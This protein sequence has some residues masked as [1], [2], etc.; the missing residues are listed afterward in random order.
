MVEFTRSGNELLKRLDGEA[1]LRQCLETLRTCGL[2]RV[3]CAQLNAEMENLGYTMQKS[4]ESMVGAWTSDL[5]RH[6]PF[7]LTLS[8]LIALNAYSAEVEDLE[9][10]F[11]HDFLIRLRRS[12]FGAVHDLSLIH[13]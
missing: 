2:A 11:D 8:E 13:I 7:A 9:R 12:F 6:A 10:K 4:V 1:E 5:S 3:A